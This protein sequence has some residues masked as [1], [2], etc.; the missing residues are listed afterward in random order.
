MLY[1]IK[2][3]VE[4]IL[5]KY[6][7][8]EAY[9][10]FYKLFEN[11][12]LEKTHIIDTKN[13]DEKSYS[14]FNNLKSAILGN[15]NNCKK[16][17]DIIGDG[18]K[19]I[20]VK[21]KKIFKFHIES[22]NQIPLEILH[23]ADSLVKESALSSK[24][25]TAIDEISMFFNLDYNETLNESITDA[26]FTFL[27]S[28]IKQKIKIILVLNFKQSSYFNNILKIYKECNTDSCFNLIFSSAEKEFHHFNIIF[29]LKSGYYLNKVTYHSSNE[30]KIFNTSNPKKS[31]KP[32]EYLL[33]CDISTEIDFRI[34]DNYDIY[35]DESS[36][37]NNPIRAFIKHHKIRINTIN[38]KFNTNRHNAYFD[39]HEISKKTESFIKNSH[40]DVSKKLKEFIQFLENHDKFK[41][42]SSID[43]V[44]KSL[45]TS[46]KNLIIQELKEARNELIVLINYNRVIE[47]GKVKL[48][49]L[50]TT[51]WIIFILTE[52]RIKM[53]GSYI[54]E[55]LKKYTE[56]L[57]EDDSTW[58]YI[59]HSK[60]YFQTEPDIPYFEEK[61]MKEILSFIHGTYLL[62]PNVK[63]VSNDSL[64]SEIFPSLV[65]PHNYE[66]LLDSLQSVVRDEDNRK[67]LNEKVKSSILDKR[68][69]IDWLEANNPKLKS[70]R[71]NMREKREKENY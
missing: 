34:K 23:E 58:K 61:D 19:V 12:Y 2:N 43:N 4:S 10:K 27:T 11:T 7:K 32:K 53:N 51:V 71:E 66:T 41:G 35:S 31:L 6:E 39:I 70:L 45:K 47:K 68:Q 37:K 30:F 26:F 67:I 64:L 40:K 46:E 42:A 29:K 65:F 55:T 49:I 24:S 33:K 62:T 28:A 38:D 17:K 14:E 13:K 25:I 57:R 69:A 56:S 9:E 44:I 59:R 22:K 48:T 16:I 52:T 8:R 15:I 1:K 21:E 5:E 63:E 60:E 36:S 54:D 20:I 50:L 18:A 3:N